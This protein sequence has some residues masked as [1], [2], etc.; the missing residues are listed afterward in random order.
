MW[1]VLL[2]RG[3]TGAIHRNSGAAIPLDTLPVSESAEVVIDRV[4]RIGVEVVI[5]DRDSRVSSV[6]RNHFGSSSQ[7][8]TQ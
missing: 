7:G 4:F 1:S 6:Q 2:V 5:L 8:P 3:E